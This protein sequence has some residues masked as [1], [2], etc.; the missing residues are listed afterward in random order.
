MIEAVAFLCRLMGI[1]DFHPTLFMLGA[2]QS[3]KNVVV[4][5]TTRGHQR[6]FKFLHIVASTNLLFLN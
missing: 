1:R 4:F 5:T 2:L 6:K 3:V